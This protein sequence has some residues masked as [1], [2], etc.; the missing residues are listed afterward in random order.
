MANFHSFSPNDIDSS[1]VQ[2]YSIIELVA[3]DTMPELN[4]IL[5]DSNT[6]LAGQ[7]LDATNHATWA[8][9]SLAA[10]DTVKMKFRKKD[11][12][13]ILETITGSIVGDGTAGNVIMTWLS[14][15]LDGAEGIYEGE[16]E[17]TYDNG[18]ISTVR[19][20]LKFD[21]RAGF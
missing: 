13:T 12:T 17:I 18:K 2:Y 3:G 14:S 20:L 8:I 4:I 1:T 10:V 21:V 15:T 7:T 6:A 19:D 5:K 9:I 11:T 16:I